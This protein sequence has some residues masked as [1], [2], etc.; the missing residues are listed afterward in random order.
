M[1]ISFSRSTRALDHDSFHPSLLGV[2]VAC[3]V[4]I[5][6]GAWFVLARVTLQET[7]NQIVLDREGALIATFTAEQI[8]RI[9]P[10]QDARVT[11]LATPN[12]P[13]KIVRAQVAEVANR[14]AN[15]MM[16][17]TV[18]LFILENTPIASA[19]QVHIVIG[20]LSPLMFVLRQM[21]GAGT[22]REN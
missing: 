11:I 17:N 15:R 6:W 4:L 16:P 19:R 18:R 22:L 21:S 3:L 2:S 9:R 8:A 5:V 7:S 20:E 13:E 10:G 14:S 12:A 1:S